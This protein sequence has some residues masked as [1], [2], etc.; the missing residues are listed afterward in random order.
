[1]YFPAKSWCQYLKY[2]VNVIFN[3]P[4]F[5]APLRVRLATFSSDEL[6]TNSEHLGTNQ[7][8]PA[9]WSHSPSRLRDNA[10]L[11]EVFEL[12][13]KWDS[14]SL[15]FS[16]TFS[17]SYKFISLYVLFFIFIFIYCYILLQFYSIHIISKKLCSSEDTASCSLHF[18]LPISYWTQTPSSLY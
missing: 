18:L 10:E 16:S 11:C 5:F 4:F 17:W 1:M 9:M 8:F 12:S 3:Y 15:A 7:N 13:S 6:P 14:F 2:L